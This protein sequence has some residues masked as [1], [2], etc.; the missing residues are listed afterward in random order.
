MRRVAATGEQTQNRIASAISVR[1]CVCSREENPLA[2]AK[3]RVTAAPTVNTPSAYASAKLRVTDGST[4]MPGP[5]VV[6][7]VIFF[8]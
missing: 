3:S 5:V 1:L 4:G 6:D 2:S 8:R 7:T